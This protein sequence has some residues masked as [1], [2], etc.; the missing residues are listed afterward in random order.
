MGHLDNAGATQSDDNQGA[1]LKS[2]LG[3]TIC[4]CQF[5]S[6]DWVHAVYKISITERSYVNTILIGPVFP[7]C[8]NPANYEAT[9]RPRTRFGQTGCAIFARHCISNLKV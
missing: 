4:H 1:L 9:L 3:T 8:R 2:A 6:V 7:D 5:P